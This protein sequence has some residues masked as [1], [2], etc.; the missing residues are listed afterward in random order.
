[1]KSININL[2]CVFARLA[3]PLRTCV[4]TIYPPI[5]HLL[6][7]R[8]V[9]LL[10]PHDALAWLVLL[11]APLCRASSAISATRSTL[12]TDPQRSYK[13]THQSDRYTTTGFSGFFEY[14]TCILQFLNGMLFQICVRGKHC[15]RSNYNLETNSESWW[16]AMRHT[17]HCLPQHKMHLSTFSTPSARD[18]VPWRTDL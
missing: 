7:D 12:L 17:G 9:R 6:A 3:L 10:G 4:R 8:R 11:S 18:V 5:L 13:D 15:H 16:A 14:S 1:M 2:M